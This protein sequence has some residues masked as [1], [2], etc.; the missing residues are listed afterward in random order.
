MQPP[1]SDELALDRMRKTMRPL[2]LFAIF[3]VLVIG[4]AAV[5]SKE[6]EHPTYSWRYR[7]TVEVE[8][9]GE[10]HLGSSVIEVQATKQTQHPIPNIPLY[11]TAATGQAVFID[12]GRGRNVI[13]LLA[14]D[15]AK[16]IDYPYYVVPFHVD[17]KKEGRDQ[18]VFEER[19]SEWDLARDKLPTFMTFGDINDPATGREISVDEFEKVLGP[20]VHFHRVWIEGTNDPVSSGIDKRFSWWKGP[21]P[22]I[23]PLGTAPGI[24]VDT[25]PWKSFRWTKQML[26][27][28]F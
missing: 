10:I 11:N 27:R 1:V 7:M 16:N 2:G 19:R 21:F 5:W 15:H 9:G 8:A 23:K 14:G 18:I 13:A 25:R 20:D 12:L 6:T 17:L 22:W 28:S 26:Q 4:G 24:Y 3:I